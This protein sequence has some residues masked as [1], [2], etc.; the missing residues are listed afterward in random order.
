MAMLLNRSMGSRTL[1]SPLRTLTTTRSSSTN[2]LSQ[3][4]HQP[5]YQA[6]CPKSYHSSRTTSQTIFQTR[7]QS[8]TTSS[9][10][11]PLKV[12]DTIPSGTFSYI[13]YTPELSSP[14]VCGN[15]IDL[16]TDQW[17]GKKIVLFGVPGAFTKTCSANHLPAYVKKAGELKSKGISGIYCIASN[18]A[19]VMSGW[20]RLLGSNEHV[21]MISDSTLKWLEEAGLTVDL[22]AHGLGKRGTR[23][24]LVIDDLKVTYVG[25]EESPGSVSVSG[26]DA[27]LPK[28]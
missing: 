13:P 21:E 18:D 23:F 4:Q 16:K 8:T 14:T 26:V 27:V 17:K 25:I 12:G 7:A 5:V 10:K 1:V 19:F 20:G 3:L 22:S 28:L 6:Y 24:A 9:K 15:A 11:M 2:L